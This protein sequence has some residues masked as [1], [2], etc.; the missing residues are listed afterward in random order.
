MAS[1]S[2]FALVLV[3]AAS[4]FPLSGCQAVFGISAPDLPSP[5]SWVV[6]DPFECG[7]VELLW[8]TCKLRAARD[9]YRIDDDATSYTKRTVVTNWKTEL[10][11]RSN[12]G[13]RTRRFVEIVD[14]PERERWYRVRVATVMQRNADVD[15]PLNPLAAK[16]RD[17][18]SDDDD[19]ERVGFLIA[20]AFRELG[21]SKEFDDR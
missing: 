4:A 1:W 19:A 3:A 17:A 15:D 16:W 20:A 13:R 2:R 11:L 9:G 21:P 14:F 12:D 5:S 18:E 6:S 8:D 10:A 7:D